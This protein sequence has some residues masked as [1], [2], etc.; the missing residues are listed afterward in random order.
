[1]L[2]DCW[3]QTIRQDGEKPPTGW[4]NAHSETSTPKGSHRRPP[5]QNAGAMRPKGSNKRHCRKKTPRDGVAIVRRVN[6][7][8]RSPPAI[9]RAQSIISRHDSR[10]QATA[11]TAVKIMSSSL[12]VP[13]ALSVPNRIT[14]PFVLFAITP[15][16]PSC[17]QAKPQSQPA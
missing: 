9:E 11:R 13:L 15:P 12:L 14:A 16:L 17:F 7:P 1:M 5:V 6:D 8:P 10:G 2:I 4:R 3:I